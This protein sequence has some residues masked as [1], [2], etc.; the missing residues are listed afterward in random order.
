MKINLDIILELIQREN[1]N[2]STLTRMGLYQLAINQTISSPQALFFG[3]GGGYT[4][5]LISLAKGISSQLPLHQDILMIV[6]EYGIFGSIALYYSFLRKRKWKWY[7][8]FILIVGT[9]YNVVISPICL[10]L[11]FITANSERQNSEGIRT[12]DF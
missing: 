9:F 11:T 3:S 1:G 7:W 4:R 5:N 6:C 12:I 10:L 2:A 8:W